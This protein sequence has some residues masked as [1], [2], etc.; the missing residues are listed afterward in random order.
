[1]GVDIGVGWGFVVCAALVRVVKTVLL[2][3]GSEH[4]IKFV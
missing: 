3:F 4:D 2:L 1:M